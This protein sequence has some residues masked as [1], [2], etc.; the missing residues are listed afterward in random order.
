MAYTCCKVKVVA[1][2]GNQRPNVQAVL[3]FGANAVAWLEQMESESA[4]AIVIV[5]CGY[6]F[7]HLN[8]DEVL[9]GTSSWAEYISETGLYRY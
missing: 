7:G 4:C 5:T 2:D 3:P 6:G 9:G 8:L 1:R